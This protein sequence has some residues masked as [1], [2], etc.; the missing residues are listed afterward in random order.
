M[1]NVLFFVN[2]YPA[3]ANLQESKKVKLKKQ[4]IEKEEKT[5]PATKVL[6]CHTSKKE[7]NHNLKNYRT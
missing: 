1:I 4:Q 3:A 6:T 7:P 2:I 5:S